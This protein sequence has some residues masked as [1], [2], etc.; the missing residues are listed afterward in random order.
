MQAAQICLHILKPGP[1]PTKLIG[2]SAIFPFEMQ[3]HGL[4]LVAYLS[5]QGGISL[6]LLPQ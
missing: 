6:Y 3:A 5:P 1:H 4:H 2:H